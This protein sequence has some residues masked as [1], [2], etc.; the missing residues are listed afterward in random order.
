MLLVGGAAIYLVLNMET[1]VA[2]AD[3]DGD[4]VDDETYHYAGET[5]RSIDIDSNADRKI[6]ARWINDSN[7]EARLFESDDNFDGRFDRR[8]VYENGWMTTT[9][10]DENGDGNP[11]M[12]THFVQDHG[13]QRGDLRRGGKTCRRARE[14]HGRLA[15]LDRSR[16]G[17]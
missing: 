2:T 7:G 8:N 1:R 4:G 10:F 12:V 16:H 11:D 17:W 14:F 5:I 3:R 15:H 9:T 13:Q 6:D